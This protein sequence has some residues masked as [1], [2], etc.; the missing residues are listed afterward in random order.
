M[1]HTK[2]QQQ[3]ASSPTRGPEQCNKAVPAVLWWC[4]QRVICYF[5]VQTTDAKHTCTKPDH[6]DHLCD[7]K[8][9]ANSACSALPLLVPVYG[10][11]AGTPLT[12]ITNTACGCHTSSTPFLGKPAKYRP[13]ALRA[14]LTHF[15]VPAPLSSVAHAGHCPTYFSFNAPTGCLCCVRVQSQ[16]ELPT[17]YRAGRDPDS[18]REGVT[19]QRQSHT[20]LHTAVLGWWSPLQG[21]GVGVIV[22]IVQLVCWI[23]CVHSCQ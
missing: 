22:A 12:A 19:L 2:G 10:A 17:K 21:V 23:I 7:K 18:E 9:E 20:G 4:A 11:C 8:V 1:L 6:T 13:S 14:L 16:W 5:D 3:A 15:A